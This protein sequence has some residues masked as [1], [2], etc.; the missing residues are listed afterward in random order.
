MASSG[1]EGKCS[2]GTND[3]DSESSPKENKKSKINLASLSLNL[4]RGRSLPL[5]SK[6]SKKSSNTTEGDDGDARNSA[7]K[8]STKW[9]LK[10]YCGRKETRSSREEKPSCCKCTCY[11]QRP[12]EEEQPQADIGTSEDITDNNTNDEIPAQIVEEVVV[13]ENIVVPDVIINTIDSAT[14]AETNAPDGDP[15]SSERNSRARSA[16]IEPNFVAVW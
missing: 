9:P 15:L 3:S 14:Y 2:C 13:N 6:R 10:F 8:K 1:V 11:K 12:T 7:S 16:H 4:R 5:K